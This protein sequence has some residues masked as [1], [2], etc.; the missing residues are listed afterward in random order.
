MERKTKQEIVAA[1]P[2]AEPGGKQSSAAMW[3]TAD[4]PGNGRN[5]NR[6]SVDETV[7]EPN[8]RRWLLRNTDLLMLM[9][10]AIVVMGIWIVAELSDA[11]LEGSTQRYDDHV[12]AW[13]RS[14]KDWT[15]PAGPAWFAA[16]WTDI[17]SLGSGSVLALVTFGCAG[18][19]MLARRYRMLIVLLIVAGGGAFLSVWMKQFFNRP[20]PPYAELMP[21]VITPSFPS[22]HSML[23]AIVYM[24]LAVFLARAS[25]RRRFKVYFISVGA[26]VTLLV[27]VSRVYLGVHYPTDVLAGWSSGLTWAM[28]CW[29]VIYFLQQTGLVERSGASKECPEP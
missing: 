28:L 8:P 27:G 15:Q 7:N 20:R 9:A 11:V 16:M 1:G 24:T 13:L 6:D 25:R 23:S 14:S 19:L 3:V 5:G 17:S 4:L 10:L 2:F 21:Y 12:L 29:L 22:G 26:I 18:G